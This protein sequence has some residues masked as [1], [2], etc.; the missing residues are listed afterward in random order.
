MHLTDAESIE[1]LNLT[2]SMS[3]RYRHWRIDMDDLVQTVLCKLLSMQGR[4]H[5]V[6]GWLRTTTKNTA[7]DLAY[8]TFSSKRYKQK[9]LRHAVSEGPFVDYVTGKGEDAV[10]CELLLDRI[11]L[12]SPPH[13][14]AIKL[15]AAGYSYE[16]IAQLTQNKKNTIRS[17]IHYARKY[18]SNILQADKHEE[19]PL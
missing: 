17:R 19:K 14:V 4:P 3:S 2:Y 13:R 5:N 7:I 11:E 9:S 16:E 18:L 15:Y 10:E 6:P 1:L 8:E 12:L